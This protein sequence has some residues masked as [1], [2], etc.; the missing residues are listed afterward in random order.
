M[1][2]DPRSPEKIA[3][4]RQRYGKPFAPEVRVKREKA[5]SYVLAHISKQVEENARAEAARKATTDQNVQPMR[6]KGQS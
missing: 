4:A 2:N 6:R 5:P 3:A 1:A